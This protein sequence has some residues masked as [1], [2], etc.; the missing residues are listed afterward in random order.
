MFTTPEFIRSM[1][2]P[3][4][5]STEFAIHVRGPTARAVRLTVPLGTVENAPKFKASTLGA[6]PRASAAPQKV[7]DGGDTSNPPSVVDDPYK[8]T[9]L[10]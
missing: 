8:A 1:K 5:S 6:S 4:S 9:K 2:P 10:T 3:N 7:A